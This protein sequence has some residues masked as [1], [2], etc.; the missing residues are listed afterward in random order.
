[1]QDDSTSS[2]EARQHH[3][4]RADGSRHALFVLEYYFPHV[5]GVETLF[6][7]LAMELVRAG[8][9]V[10]VV[11]LWLPGTAMR[12][13]IDGVEVIRVRTPQTG[14]RYLFMLMALPAVVRV[15]TRADLLQTTTYNAA[16]PA[17]LGGLLCRKPVIITVHEVFGNQWQQLPGLNPMVGWAYRLFEA[18]VLRL[19]FARYICDS[20]FTRGRLAQFIGIPSERSS[21][22]YPAVDHDFW[23]LGRHAARPLREQLGIAPDTFVYLYFG[24]PGISKG[25]EFLVEAASLVRNAIPRSQLVL[26]LA[27]DPADHYQRILQHIERLN[28]SAHVRILDPVPRTEL[29]SYLLAADRV[30]VPSLSEGFGYAAFEAASL[31]CTVVATAGHAVEEVAGDSVTLVPP[32][33]AGALAD[34][35]IATSTQC[36][37]PGLAVRFDS[38]R[39]LQGMLAQYA[40][41][42]G[43]PQHGAIS[44]DADEPAPC[45]GNWHP[46]APNLDPN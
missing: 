13:T 10:T 34:A 18:G 7:Q 26:L 11:T 4:Q 44:V 3:A 9:A 22:V 2:V 30:V 19:P 46:S 5:G 31:G 28:L 27:R 45:R 8:W 17:W 37:R 20:R 16:V 36:P 42:L 14:R 40:H 25:L 38:A 35:I 29:P 32:R 43:L 21:V 41:I 33:D 12:E 1:M 23:C 15:A 39:H 24:R 6:R